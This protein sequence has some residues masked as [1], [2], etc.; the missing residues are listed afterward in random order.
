[1]V[2]HR[3]WE[4]EREKMQPLSVKGPRG[5]QSSHCPELGPSNMGGEHPRPPWF[6]PK[7]GTLSQMTGGTEIH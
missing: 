2:D 3:P 4:Q 5:P 6:L 7:Q 1:M